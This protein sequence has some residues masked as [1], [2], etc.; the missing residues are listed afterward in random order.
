M[1][2]NMIIYIYICR[3]MSTEKIA[4]RT[5]LQILK[6]NKTMLNGLKSV[7]V[8]TSISMTRTV[9]LLTADNS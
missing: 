5:I 3:N 8:K 1:L 4:D 2:P 9:Y 6:D 7:K